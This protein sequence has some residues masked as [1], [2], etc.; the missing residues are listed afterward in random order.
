MK[1]DG[2]QVQLLTEIKAELANMNKC[3]CELRDDLRTDRV[4]HWR[5]LAL[6]IL[7]A[8]ALIG[9]KLAYP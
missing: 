7:G 6:V 2:Q 5:I 8:F 1:D 9:V 4:W 3:L